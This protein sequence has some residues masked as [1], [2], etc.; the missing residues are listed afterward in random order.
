[1]TA[2]QAA[3]VLGVITIVILIVQRACEEQKYLLVAAGAALTASAGYLLELISRDMNAAVMGVKFRCIG[4][5]FCI[6]MLVMFSL[7]FLGDRISKKLIVLWGIAIAIKCLL[8]SVCDVKTA[9]F[10]NGLY[11]AH[12]NPGTPGTAGISYE[13]EIGYY[14]GAAVD[15]LGILYCIGAGL[16]KLV[17]MTRKERRGFLWIVYSSC[18]SLLLYFAYVGGLFGQYEVLPLCLS[19]M[20]AVITFV[21]IWYGMFRVQYFA[22]S[23][24]MQ[25]MVQGMIVIDNYYNL[26]EYNQ[27]AVKLFP[28]LAELKKGE[29]VSQYFTLMKLFDQGDEQEFESEGCY[30]KAQAAPIMDKLQ[31][32][33]YI[34]WIYDV[35]QTKQNMDELIRLKEQ[36]DN[37]NKEKSNFLANM[38]HEIRTPMNVII[39]ST[40]LI[41]REKASDAVL[42]NASTIKQAGQNLLGIIND[43]LDFS[44]IEAGKVEITPVEYSVGLMISDLVNMTI[45]RMGDKNIDLMVDIDPQLPKQLY[46]DDIRVKQ[47]II[48]FLTNA[49][50]FTESGYIR[51]KVRLLKQYVQE[52]KEIANVRFE[53]EDTGMGIKKENLKSLFD[54]FSRFDTIK[55]RAVEGT[56]LGLAISLML[57][58]NMNGKLSVQSKYGTGSCFSLDIPQVIC[59][60][61]D[62]EPPLCYKKALLVEKNPLHAE[63]MRST[64][65]QID[66]QYDIAESEEQFFEM[67]NR[68][69]DILFVDKEVYSSPLVTGLKADKVVMLDKQESVKKRSDDD[70]LIMKQMLGVKLLSV[71]NKTYSREVRA[72][73]KASE[74]E[75][76]APEARVLIVDDNAVN[77]KIATG[78]LKPFGLQVDVADSGRR[79]IA[80]VEENDYDI[81][82]MDHMMPEMDGIETTAHIRAKVGKKFQEVVI[83]ALTANAVNGAKNVFLSSGMQDFLSKPIEMSRMV[84]ILRRWLP[85][86]KIIERKTAHGIRIAGFDYEQGMKNC[87]EDE[88]RYH[89]NLKI[90]KMMSGRFMEE[91]ASNMQ[92]RDLQSIGRIV[93]TFEA[94]S[95]KVGAVRFAKFLQKYD[96]ACQKQNEKYIINNYSFLQ[97]LYG[98]LEEAL[99]SYLDG[100][101]E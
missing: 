80:K 100:E 16:R 86:E 55:N 54:S 60:H 74:Q 71:L 17:R 47:I 28:E 12:I 14:V 87:G 99:Q 49:V 48:N 46:G 22:Q 51:L 26:L 50:K 33:G 38:S 19:F 39:G 44:K 88:K 68:S 61:E 66:I 70:I 45:V 94:E 93:H 69:Y 36:A 52:D 83:V 7:E 90:Y 81:I 73:A 6:F 96:E 29:K 43:I 10:L 13:K 67:L 101:K 21:V 11:F 2:Q 82:F 97:K 58:Q 76:T 5:T 42:E 37:S 8:V 9:G 4:V 91:I 98:E 35:T 79:A 72:N 75:F 27:P 59:R 65:S 31:I 92:A 18:I 32:V 25:K 62:E 23:D 95:T 53:V 41:L 85:K 57:A 1:M 3:V 78:L 77:L 15:V 30:Y 84:E 40:E 89:M 63:I 24:M 20:C 56:G 64:L 34:V